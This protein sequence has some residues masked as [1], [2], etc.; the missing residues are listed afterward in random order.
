MIW[1]DEHADSTYRVVEGHASWD[2]SFFVS[3]LCSVA[4][5]LKLFLAGKCWGC[6]GRV[7][8]MGEHL[9]DIIL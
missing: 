6:C 9:D 2:N 3:A 1:A 5:V 8:F 7:V 4:F